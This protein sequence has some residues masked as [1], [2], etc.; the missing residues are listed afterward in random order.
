[1]FVLVLANRQSVLGD[2]ANGPVFRATATVCVAGVGFLALAV[3]V[4]HL[5]GKG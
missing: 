4:L 3:V 2:A 5:L 1:V